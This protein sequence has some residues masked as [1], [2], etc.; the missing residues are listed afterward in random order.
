MKAIQVKYLSATNNLG[1]RMKVFTEA[2][3]LVEGR[4]P[5]LEHEDQARLLVERYIKHIGWQVS[6]KGF[7]C[8]PN[9]DYVATLGN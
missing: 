3:S 8:L 4:K 5:E 6:I 9:G 2:G 7:G 1:A